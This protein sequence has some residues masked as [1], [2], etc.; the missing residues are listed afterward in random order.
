[1]WIFWVFRPHTALHYT[2][3]G[4]VWVLSPLKTANGAKH[5]VELGKSVCNGHFWKRQY[6]PQPASL[7]NQQFKHNFSSHQRKIL[8]V[9]ANKVPKVPLKFR[10]ILI[11]MGIY[12]LNLWKTLSLGTMKFE[13]Q[14]TVFSFGRRFLSAWQHTSYALEKRPINDVKEK[15]FILIIKSNT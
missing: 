10:G 5:E 8:S 14:T 2:S 6:I 3:H 9:A 11:Y 12:M 15:M 4:E 7:T 13:G 1:M